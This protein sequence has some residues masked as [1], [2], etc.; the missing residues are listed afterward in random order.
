[1]RHFHLFTSIVLIFGCIN[2]GLAQEKKSAFQKNTHLFT[3]GYGAGNFS[4]DYLRNNVTAANETN[5]RFNAVGPL[6]GK[7]EFAIE[8]KIGFGINFAYMK[9]TLE[10]TDENS[11]NQEYDAILSCETMSFLARFNY[12][13]G[14]NE[15]VD[16]YVGLG[17]GVR[18]LS[19]FY[20]DND[21][22]GNTA[23]NEK[24]VDYL[25]FSGH[26]PIGLDLTF[27]VRFY[28]TSVV[29]MYVETGIAKGVI[30][31]GLS[32]KI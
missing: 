9:N 27:G 1:M 22:S 2:F 30:Q 18:T 19:W 4:Q 13:I 32:F 31:G 6:F 11:M 10:Y 16:P 15:R 28:P 14:H 7:Y 21:P 23:Q 29:G 5:S 20:D 24:D 17:L 8:N 25:G 26:F 12:H 3:I